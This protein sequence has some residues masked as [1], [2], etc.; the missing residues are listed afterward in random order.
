VLP[1]GSKAILSCRLSYLL[2]LHWVRFLAVL[3]GRVTD[4]EQNEANYKRESRHGW[5][6]SLLESVRYCELANRLLVASGTSML[7]TS[8]RAA[9]LPGLTYSGQ[10]EAV[11][12]AGARVQKFGLDQLWKVGS[13][14]KHSHKKA[15][16]VPSRAVYC[17]GPGLASSF[18]ERKGRTRKPHTVRQNPAD[19]V[20]ENGRSGD[21]G[22]AAGYSPGRRLCYAW[23]P[24]ASEHIRT[25]ANTDISVQN[26]RTG[27]INPFCAAEGGA[28][29]G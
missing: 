16:R 9:L 25:R 1:G 2:A 8:K 29:A 17:A 10:S 20:R 21:E 27:K 13:T 22:K 12:H 19:A 6:M 7:A 23:G 24:A 14:I 3:S 11:S 4:H 15:L 26:C 28:E 18:F 5:S